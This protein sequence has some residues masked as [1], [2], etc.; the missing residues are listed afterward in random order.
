MGL[1]P[2]GIAGTDDIFGLSERLWGDYPIDYILGYKDRDY[3][4]GVFDDFKTWTLSTAL[5]SS[6]GFYT[7]EGNGY[8]TFEKAGG[9][10][11]QN[12]VPNNAVYTIPSGYPIQLLCAG[13]TPSPG[14][15]IQYPVGT[16]LYT[17]GQLVLMGSGSAAQND[18]ASLQMGGDT[19]TTNMLPFSVVPGVSGS[20]IFECR[21]KISALATAETTFFVGLAGGGSAITTRP[22][23]AS[24]FDVTTSLLGFGCKRADALNTLYCVHGRHGG[25]VVQDSTALLTLGA[26]PNSTNPAIGPAVYFKL[27]FI[28]DGKY[29]TWTPYVNGIPQDGQLSA[30]DRR[31]LKGTGT[32]LTGTATWPDDSLSLCAGIF[33]YGSAIQTVTLDWWAA[34]QEPAIGA[35]RKP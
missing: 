8:R 33:Q 9:S 6:L 2:K 31:I 27:G 25:T 11:A 26:W 32:G 22:A 34:A 28:Y 1:R 23:A 20:L 3:G 14:Q 29:Q 5:S 21:L 18:E 17:P 4:W 10:S 13:N 7:S 12:I 30:T 24:A 15:T 16:K 35:W 19:A